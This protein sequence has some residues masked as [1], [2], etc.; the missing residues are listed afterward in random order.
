MDRKEKI[1]IYIGP[2]EKFNEYVLNYAEKDGINYN[3]TQLVNLSEDERKVLLLKIDNVTSENKKEEAKLYINL[4]TISSN[5]YAGVTEAVT[6]NFVNFI[7]K[8]DINKII[9]QNPPNE[10]I[11]DL[12]KQYNS[13]DIYEYHYDYGKIDNEFILKFKK[14]STSIILGQEAALDKVMQALIIQQKLNMGDK[15]IVIM[16]YGPSGVGKTETGRL[17]AKLLGEKMFY[18]Q[19]SMFQ[20]EGHLNYLYGDKIQLPSFAKDL[21]NRTSNIIFL[22]EFDKANK[23]VYSALYQ[24]FDTGEYEDKNFKVDLKNTIIICT[25]NY[26]NPKNILEH[27][28]GP[29]FFRINC[30]IKYEKLCCFSSNRNF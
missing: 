6:S 10:I 24:L 3:L 29:M 7:S 19:F 15:P 5:E 25:S 21:L 4:L 11:N 1:I 16:L 18:S 12:Y 22:D 23:F 27:L 8:Y 17:I 20:N 13:E 2:V 14:E 30:F 26:N 28:G 9:I